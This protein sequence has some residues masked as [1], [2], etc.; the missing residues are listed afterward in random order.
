MTY[1]DITFLSDI[2]VIK[3]LDKLHIKENIMFTFKVL[4]KNLK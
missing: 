4:E 2:I 3:N 1:I